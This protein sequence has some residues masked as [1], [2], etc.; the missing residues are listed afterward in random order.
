MSPINEVLE[1]TTDHEVHIERIINAPPSLVFAA[2]AD[3]RHLGK[4]YAPPGCTIEIKTY[5]FRT[6]GAFHTCIH[7]PDGKE[8][9]CSGVFESIIAPEKIV[10]SMG[11]C[12]ADGHPQSAIEAGMNPAWPD[13]TTVTVTLEALG[14]RTRLTLRQTVSEALAKETGAH[15]SWLLMLDGLEALLE[16]GLDA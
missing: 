11:V 7:V 15:P 4:W 12:D 10:Y 1:R 16:D 14:E 8:C 13:E 3:A 2:W 6:G 9:W 5:D